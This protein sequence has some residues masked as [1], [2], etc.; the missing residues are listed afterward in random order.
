VAAMRSLSARI[1]ARDEGALVRFRFRAILEVH[2]GA[3]DRFGAGLRANAATFG[4]DTS[5][6]EA[7]LWF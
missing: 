3:G 2:P 6:G 1:M 7:D 5:D 4:G